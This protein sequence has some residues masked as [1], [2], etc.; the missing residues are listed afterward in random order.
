MNFE[1][2][3]K[4][5]AG[6][7]DKLL[8]LIEARE[9]DIT[10]LSL[11]EV[12]L[13]FLNYIKTLEKVE[14]SVLAEF[15]QIATQLLVIKSKAL[16]P[17]LDLSPEEVES[18]VE[19]ENRLKFHREFRNVEKNFGLLWKNSNGAFSRSLFQGRP[20]TFYPPEN[21]SVEDI[22][23]TFLKIIDE[24]KIIAPLETATLK[25]VIVSIEDK[26][27]ELM[28]RVSEQAELD[29]MGLVRNK[30]KS[31]VIATFLAILH[32]LKNQLINI[33]Q[34]GIFSDIMISTNNE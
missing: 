7:L 9:L 25:R 19:L 27:D 16:L 32:L 14:T 23:T 10:Q 33:E 31:E 4:Q 5:Y 13:D 17:A 24:L 2:Q 11:A 22:A 6:P 29:F 26:I 8:E 20:V 30:P 3:T 34:N 21:L 15:L 1:L 18:A 28:A 12:T